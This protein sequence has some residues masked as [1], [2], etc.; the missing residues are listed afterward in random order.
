MHIDPFVL[1]QIVACC[2]IGSTLCSALQS[3]KRGVVRHSLAFLVGGD[4]SEPIPDVVLLEELLCQVLEIPAQARVCLSAA[5]EIAK[6]A[7]GHMG[8]DSSQ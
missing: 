6:I 7:A 5:S 1:A 8:T 4:D 2:Q 3:G